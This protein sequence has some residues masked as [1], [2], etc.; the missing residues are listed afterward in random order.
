[1]VM[2]KEDA[3]KIKEI[4]KAYSLRS[5]TAHTR[6]EVLDK[7]IRYYRNIAN[8]LAAFLK[9]DELNNNNINCAAVVANKFLLSL[10]ECEQVNSDQLIEELDY[11]DF[12]MLNNQLKIAIESIAKSDHISVALSLICF[13]YF[14]DRHFIKNLGSQLLKK[15]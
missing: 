15:A 12:N 3:D 6:D 9:Q 7:M 14:I 2:I 4:I 8:F 13:L 1:M 11:Y 10:L 5:F